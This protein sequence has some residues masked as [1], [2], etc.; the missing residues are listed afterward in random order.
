MWEATE[1][2]SAPRTIKKKSRMTIL[3]HRES[4]MRLLISL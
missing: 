1:E 4:V 2:S 3:I